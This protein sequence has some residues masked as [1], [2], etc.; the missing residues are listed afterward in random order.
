[1]T[2]A[3]FK[4]WR[5]RFFKSQ[6]AAADALGISASSVIL[7][8]AGRRRDANETPVEVPKVVALACSAV[9]QNLPPYGDTPA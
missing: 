7:Y 8:E 6:R 2:P 9:A 1:V 5:K 3:Q 4:D